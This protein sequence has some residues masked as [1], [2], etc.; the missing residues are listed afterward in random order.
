L[1]D[2]TTSESLELSFAPA[3]A[4]DHDELFSLYSHVVAE[5]GAFHHGPPVD[6]SVFAG[7]WLEG[8]TVWV[9]RSEG[10]LAG[11]YYIGP[12]FSGLAAHIA[13]GGY[14]VHPDFRRRGVGTALVEHSLVQARSEGFDALMFNLVIESNPSRRIYERLGFELLG[15]I[16]DAIEG[17]TALMYWRAL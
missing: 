1:L 4:H 10:A 9:A 12:N 13:N 15:R 3:T 5:G 6:E 14:M 16:P 17:R 7:A 8:R 2:V 11:A